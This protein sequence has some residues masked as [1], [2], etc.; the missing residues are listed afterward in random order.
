MSGQIS[1]HGFDQAAIE[2]LMM[3]RLNG[4]FDYEA[5][6]EL[7]CKHEKF[8]GTGCNAKG[9]YSCD[10]KFE[11]ALSKIG[12]NTNGYGF[13]GGI[14]SFSRGCANEYVKDFHVSYET[15]KRPRLHCFYCGR[16]DEIDAKYWDG[17]LGGSNDIVRE[18]AVNAWF[19]NHKMEWYVQYIHIY[20]MY[21][22]YILYI[23]I[24]IAYNI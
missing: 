5:P 19:T 10:Y 21:I 13:W 14:S 15:V 1:C 9:D 20:S 7:S 3:Q 18:E 16:M 17:P 23:V 12:F 24:V 6:F 8:G 4:T 22:Q 2:V 11:K